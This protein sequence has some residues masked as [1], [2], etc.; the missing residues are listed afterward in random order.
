MSRLSSV[1]LP[2]NEYLGIL[3]TLAGIKDVAVINH[4]TAGC[5]FYELVTASKRTRELIY[6]RFASTSLEQED[7]ALSGGEEKLR[8]IIKEIA[9]KDHVSL[10]VIVS[11]PVASLIGVD[12]EAIA[13]EVAPNI[14]QPILSFNNKA[15][16][17][18][19]ENGVEEA[20]FSLIRFYCR[21]SSEQK[22][23]PVGGT[24]KAN[25]IGPTVETFNWS[26]DE[27]ELRRLLGL[28]GI[29]VNTVLT[30]ETMTEKLKTIANADINIVSRAVG[31]KTARY[32]EDH[33]G[34]P[35]IYGL[36]YGEKGTKEWMKQV[37]E[38]VK[39]EV[40]ANGFVNDRSFSFHHYIEMIS[41]GE[42][43]QRKWTVALSCPPAMA[44]GFAQL[45]QEDWGFPLEAIRLTSTPKD[46]ELEEL[47][48]LGVKRVFVTPDEL[49]WKS[50]LK[51]IK[52]FILMGSAEDT[53]LVKEAP[54][55]LRITPPAYDRF[56]IY[57]GNPLVG[58]A[59][60]QSLTQE[61]FNQISRYALR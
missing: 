37:A 59:G 23:C 36:P 24:L 19:A 10:I 58:W 27:Q 8:A 52:P 38:A 51:E 7:I 42:F 43:F 20:L 6:N 5:N 21:E 44:K 17:E 33:F 2:T 18:D 15:W 29:D 39:K 1:F 61:L 35:Y 55:Q 40:P 3:W 45:V 31:L 26:A 49:E 4:G 28:I 13:R 11:N 54:V 25:I 14:K 41:G 30:Y 47:E 9:I 53:T 60:Y 48:A 56:T 34:I 57:D 46:S 50:V 32:L 12:V 22:A 16:K